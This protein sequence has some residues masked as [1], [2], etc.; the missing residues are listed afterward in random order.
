MSRDTVKLSKAL[1]WL[2]R[3]GAE[4]E[5]IAIDSAGYVL[6]DDALHCRR[7]RGYSVKQVEGVVNGN[8]KQ[9]FHL[10]EEGRRKYIRANQG[11]SIASVREDALLTR[12]DDS[13]AELCPEV[14]HGTYRRFWS[15]I[16]ASGGLSRMSRNHIH[17]AVELPERGGVVSGMRG[18]C[19]LIV[20][21]D[22]RNAGIWQDMEFYKSD[23][24]VI[25]TSGIDGILPLRY[26]AHVK[27]RATGEVVYGSP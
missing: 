20:T 23:N 24:G 3:H 7:L 27:D 8:D 4:Q 6:L 22:M 9:R 26:V 5:G 13:F 2:L 25:L 12:L 21:V 16:E 14:Y 11:H 17:L 15:A 18:S 19:D 10:K 1:S